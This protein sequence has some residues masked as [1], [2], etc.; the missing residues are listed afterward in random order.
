MQYKNNQHIQ[1]MV[2]E[3]GKK[4]DAKVLCLHVENPN[5]VQIPGKKGPSQK[6]FFFGARGRALMRVRTSD[7]RRVLL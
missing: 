4:V 6:E 1:K 7:L 3:T 2:I 5:S